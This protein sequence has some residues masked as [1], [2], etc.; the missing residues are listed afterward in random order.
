MKNAEADFMAVSSLQPEIVQK[1]A[2]PDWGITPERMREAVERIVA[3]SNPLRVIAFGSWARGEHQP[4]SDLD[5]AVILDEN[6]TVTSAG[7]LYECVSGIR[8][9]MDILA[10]SLERHEQFGVSVNSVHGDIKREGV[11]L[12]E[13]DRHGSP[14][15]VDAA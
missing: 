8:M 12:Y 1:S 2:V 4:D 13:R 6:S 9:S 3:A 7:T 11:V 5:I 10:V 15:A 14:S